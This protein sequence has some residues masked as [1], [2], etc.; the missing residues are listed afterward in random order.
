MKKSSATVVLI[1]GVLLIVGGIM[2]FVKA[3]SQISLILGA[4][5][6]AAAILSAW[7]MYRKKKAG[8]YAALILAFVIDALFTYRMMASGKLMPAAPI[9]ILSLIV[10]IVLAIDVRKGKG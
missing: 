9:C 7:G 4:L 6:G 10:I 2:G 3:G 5:A 1:Y 8:L